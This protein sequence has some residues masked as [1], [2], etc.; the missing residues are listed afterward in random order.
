M[1]RGRPGSACMQTGRCVSLLTRSTTEPAAEAGRIAGPRYAQGNDAWRRQ[2]RDPM[3]QRTVWLAGILV[4]GFVWPAAASNRTDDVNRINSSTQVFREVMST[5]DKGVPQELLEKAKCIAIIP[6]EKKAAL[7]I[8]GSGRQRARDLPD[9]ERMERAVVPHVGGRQRRLADRRQLDRCRDAVHERQGAAEPAQRQVPDW[10]RGVGR[11]RSGGPARGG[12]HRREAARRN[13][14]LL[15]GAAARSPAS[16]STAR[17]SSPTTPATRRCTNHV[18]RAKVLD[19]SVAVP[20]PAQPL[21]GEL[22]RYAKEAARGQ[23]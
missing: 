13:P 19:G 1:A 15:C 8:G 23:H 17:L 10:R 11:G 6:G 4:L 16:A 20:R 12:R 22:G 21:V 5:P 2:G 14:D 18:N 9:G 7:G 3:N